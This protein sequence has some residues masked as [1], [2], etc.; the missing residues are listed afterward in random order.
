MS[1]NA[2]RHVKA[3][4]DLYRA[5]A[6]GDTGQAGTIKDFYDEYFAVLD[7]TAEFYLETVERVF[8]EFLLA[9]GE[10]DWQGRSTPA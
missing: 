5:L 10:L 8:Q 6:R 4:M 7:M 9:K 3:Q 2:E 1:M